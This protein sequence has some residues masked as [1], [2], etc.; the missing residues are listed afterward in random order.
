MTI[1]IYI[2]IYIYID[3]ERERER[4]VYLHGHT[5]NKH[6]MLTR[7]PAAKEIDNTQTKLNTYRHTDTS[8]VTYTS[9]S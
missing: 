2:Y 4:E 6:Q 7:I 3:I 8:T 5:T 1:Y 9:T